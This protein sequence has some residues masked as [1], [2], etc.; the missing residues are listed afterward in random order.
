MMIFEDSYH[1]I[2]FSYKEYEKMHSPGLQASARERESCNSARSY[3]LSEQ[4]GVSDCRAQ[5]REGLSKT[6]WTG[7]FTCL[8]ESPLFFVDGAH[9]EDAALKLKVTVERYFSDYKKI[10]IMGSL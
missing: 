4:T 8:S 3:P 9:N 2:A 1:G 10:F 7:R 6:R 5:V